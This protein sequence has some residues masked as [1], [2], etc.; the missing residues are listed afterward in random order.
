MARLTVFG[1][2]TMGTALAMHSARTGVDTALWANRFDG[3]ALEGL[4]TNGKHPGLPEHVPSELAVYGPDELEQAAKDLEIAVLAA[5]SDTTRSLIGMIR[6]VTAEA[7]FV[8]SLGKGV[9][10]A[11]GMRISE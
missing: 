2:G 6:D 4:R 11:T 9:E 10:T 3:A 5:T 8:V 7:G 1:A